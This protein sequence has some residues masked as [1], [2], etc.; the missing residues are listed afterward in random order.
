MN[1]KN[2]LNFF[3]NLL[4]YWKIILFCKG[5]GVDPL[6]FEDGPEVFGQVAQHII[7]GKPGVDVLSPTGPGIGR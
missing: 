1:L 4:F 7:V 6:F 2:K 3:P 5:P